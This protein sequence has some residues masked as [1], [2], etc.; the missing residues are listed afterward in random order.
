MVKQLPSLNV[1]EAI[2]TGLMTNVPTLVKID[3]F[4]GRRHGGDLDVVSILANFKEDEAE[5]IKK[6]EEDS[7]NLGYD[8]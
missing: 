2:L 8:Y 4:K 5:E 3:E 1:G 6:Q 7:F